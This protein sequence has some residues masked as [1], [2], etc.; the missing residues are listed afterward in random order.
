MPFLGGLEKYTP[1]SDPLC[2]L[3]RALTTAVA[4]T[5]TIPAKI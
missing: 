1:P 2:P 5:A 3:I 4:A